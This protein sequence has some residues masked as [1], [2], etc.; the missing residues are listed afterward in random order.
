MQRRTILIGLVVIS[1][2]LSACAGGMDEA[3]M[4]PSKDFFFEEEAME[5][6]A[7]SEAPNFS[8][9]TVQVAFESAQ[10][11]ERLIIREGNMDIVVEN[12]D[13]SLAEITR[14]AD[15]NGGW[16]VSTNVFDSGQAKSG[17]ITIRV[18]VEQFDATMEQIRQASIE[19]RS[20]STNSQDVTEE[21]VDLDA[22]VAN[23]EA[24]ADRVRSFLDESRNVE[25]AL[26]VNQE[27]SRLEGEIES[28]KARM[29][30]LNESAAFSRLDI[31]L[32]P[33]VLSQ[34]IEIGGWQP[35]G[36]VRDAFE[37]LISALETLGTVAI[38]GG[39]FCLP[40]VL[41]IGVPLF[42][43]GRTIYRRRRAKDQVSETAGA[44]GDSEE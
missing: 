28:L 30:Y 29:K 13:D 5:E 6:S 2:F 39:V 14:L 41:L 4:E 12:T 38:W 27:L 32:T 18:P 36:V 10:V 37:M 16:V 11:Q 3:S 19:V 1:A 33:D 44:N 31:H 7:G 25:E 26:A 35:E 17:N 24:T 21:Y 20:E 34:P 23:L 43:V 15:S 9:D 22:R 40:L 42:F 8:A